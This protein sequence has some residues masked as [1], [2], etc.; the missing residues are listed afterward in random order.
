MPELRLRQLP[1]G[2]C[3]WSEILANNFFFVD[4]TA[5]LAALVCDR[6]KVFFAR[7]DGMGKTLLCSMLKELFTH[8]TQNFEGTAIY[9]DWPEDRCYPVIS[10]NFSA[11][12]CADFEQAQSLDYSLPLYNFLRR[13]DRFAGKKQ[14]VFLVDDWDRPLTRALENP[15][16]D[17]GRAE[18]N[19]AVAIMRVFYSWLNHRDHSRF[20]FSTGV[21]RFRDDLFFIGEDFMD[22]SMEPGYA[23]LIGFTPKEVELYYAPYYERAAQALHTSPFFLLDDLKQNGTLHV[24]C[25]GSLSSS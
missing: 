6:R 13:L 7:P 1:L 15:D 25:I 3:S 12:Y 17:H 10:L 4:K 23:D 5:K 14:L 21:I 22:L 19:H 2:F 9:D 11:I 16:L 8:G 18:F 24:G 20:I